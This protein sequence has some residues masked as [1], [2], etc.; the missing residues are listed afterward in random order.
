MPLAGAH[1]AG[2]SRRVSR[3][4][5]RIAAAS[6]AGATGIWLAVW[7][8]QHRA[9]G[10]TSVNE[11]RLVLGLT[12]MDAAKALPLAML[13]LV[14]GVEVLVRRAGSGPVRT[15]RPRSAVGLGR[16]VQT[17]LLV[18]AIGGAADFWP[19]RFGSYAE[20]FESR[21]AEGL[22]WVLLVPWQTMSCVVA[23]LLLL[24]LAVLRRRASEG[25]PAVLVILAAGFV[26][27][28]LWTP[29]WFWPLLAWTVLAVWSGWLTRRLPDAWPTFTTGG[30]PTE[31][32]HGSST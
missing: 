28:S 6:A 13:L 29:V 8:Q 32:A 30:D 24:V 20:T 5:L 26:V 22:P 25:E 19:F 3:T 7:L 27:G 12:W 21:Q 9:H 16:A 1:P 4:L 17:C 10:H 31:T 14:P 23:G 18:A 11:E 2:V 15:P